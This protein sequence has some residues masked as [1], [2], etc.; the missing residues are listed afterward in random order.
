MKVKRRTI[1]TIALL[2][3]TLL[4]AALYYQYGRPKLYRVTILPSLGGRVTWP[5]A[6]NDRGQVVGFSQTSDG[7][8]RLFLWERANGIQD[9]GPIWEGGVDIN[10]DGWI[11][12]TMLDANGNKQ[13]FIRDPNGAR[14]ML[15]TLGGRES[16]ACKLNV[17]N[18]VV[19]SSETASG[20]RH[21]FVWDRAG[22]M[23]DLGLLVGAD[24]WAKTI[25]DAG[26]L[27]GYSAGL[28]FV[29]ESNEGMVA[30]PTE[31]L[32]DLNNESFAIGEHYFPGE[33]TYAVTWRRD[34]G[35]VKLFPFEHGLLGAAMI[36][37]AG[38]VVYS[39]YCESWWD[40]LKA[41]LGRNSLRRQWFLWDPQ[42]GRISIDQCVPR[43]FGEEFFPLA[44]NNEGCIVGILVSKND[45]RSRAVLLE[46]IPEKWEK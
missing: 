32:T 33:G 24:S 4:G 10:N 42:Q 13:A 22:G 16:S 20:A 31:Y 37:D 3:V 27:F 11:A 40:R 12:G 38:Q 46:P 28:P 43:R 29:W 15:G 17:R 44:L 8:H 23:V 19:G 2:V 5:C 41:R 36:N 14:T 6:I 7:Q 21:A 25:N 45:T 18:Q 9:L 26:L 30:P 34:V 1:I 39:E 35:L